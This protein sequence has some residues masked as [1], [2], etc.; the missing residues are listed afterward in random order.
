MDITTIITSFGIIAV[1]I[2]AWKSNRSTAHIQKDI[3]NSQQAL[4]M[5][6]QELANSKKT[7]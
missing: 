7:V 6:Q 5:T 2:Q 3:V 1:A 4:V